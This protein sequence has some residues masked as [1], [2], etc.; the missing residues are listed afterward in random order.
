ML[1]IHLRC[2]R[3]ERLIAQAS[4]GHF[5]GIFLINWYINAIE[6]LEH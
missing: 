4:K 5:G 6:E 3:M 1:G 2:A